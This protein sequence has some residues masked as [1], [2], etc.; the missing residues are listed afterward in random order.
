M[1]GNGFIDMRLFF[2]KT[3]RARY[4]SHLDLVRTFTRTIRRAGLPIWYTEG[5][6]RH[7]YITFAA[8]LSLGY[9]GMEESMDF[10]LT[11]ELSC[12]EIEKRLREAMPPDVT[13]LRVCAPVMKLGKVAFSRYLIKIEKGAQWLAERLAAETIIVEKR[14][15]KGIVKEI[16]IKPHLRE[17]E[18]RQDD[19]R[20]EL[21]VTLPSGSDLNIN[22]KLLVGALECEII[23]LA[24]LN[25]EGEVFC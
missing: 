18:L 14:T 20:C 7:P 2:S 5:F 16:D 22:P 12:D 4:I 25:G 23:R 9:E 11:G 17:I 10:R 1:D 15:K 8:P 21:T 3:G 6:N 19:D 24:V 13:M